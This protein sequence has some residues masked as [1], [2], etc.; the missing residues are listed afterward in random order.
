MSPTRNSRSLLLAISSRNDAKSMLSGNNQ[1][2]PLAAP[3]SG[4]R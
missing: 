2:L 1:A 3:S 4:K